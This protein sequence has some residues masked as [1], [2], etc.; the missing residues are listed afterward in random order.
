MSLLSN[1]FSILKPRGNLLIH[2]WSLAEIVQMNFKEKTSSKI[3]EYIFEADS[4]Y[5]LNPPRVETETVMISSG[6]V[7]ETKKAVDYVFSVNEMENILNRSGFVLKENFSIPR[8]KK[9]AIGEP[10][11]YMIAEKK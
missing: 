10:R 11:A 1:I 9:F 3:G 6:G 2:T 8:K 5:L 7:T 4:K